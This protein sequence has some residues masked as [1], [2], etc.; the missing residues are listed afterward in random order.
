MSTR[1]NHSKVNSLTVPHETATSG[2]EGTLP[3]KTPVKKSANDQHPTLF[4]ALSPLPL[5]PKLEVR[6]CESSFLSSN[7]MRYVETPVPKEKSRLLPYE[8]QDH[9][10]YAINNRIIFE[11]SEEEAENNSSS[12]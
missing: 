12:V 11:S 1:N 10:S 2:S 8:E 5:P 9:I 3:P 7:E 4:P 6:I